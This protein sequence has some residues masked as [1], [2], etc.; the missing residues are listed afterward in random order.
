M[1]FKI[2]EW[3]DDDEE[4]EVKQN[5]QQPN[6]ETKSKM[7]LLVGTVICEF[8]GNDWT[9]YPLIDQDK[10]SDL[11]ISLKCP[12]LLQIP[13]K[14]EQTV[15][16]FLLTGGFDTIKKATSKL[17]LTINRNQSD[18]KE[19]VFYS[20][21]FGYNDMITPRFVHKTVNINDKYFL[22]IGGK[23]NSGW[24][25]ECELFVYESRKWI[26]FDKM[27]SKRSNFDAIL[28][29]QKI[30]VFG[31]FENVNKFSNHLVEVCD[32]SNTN[33]LSA[34]KWKALNVNFPSI[35][36]CRV[37]K[38]NEQNNIFLI[39]GCD[40]N[41][42]KKELYSF[43]TQKNE[44]KQVGILNTPRANFHTLY[45]NNDL[46]IIGGTFK[47]TSD[48]N[49]VSSN[50]IEKF[51]M[52]TFKSSLVTMDQNIFSSNISQCVDISDVSII[53]SEFGLPYSTSTQTNS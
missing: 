16:T 40:E 19:E 52:K 15:T 8:D 10:I 42:M 36:C 22:S 35:A 23:N 51:D 1:N 9:Y 7:V 18:N 48:I 43:D 45:E 30:Y 3:K 26:V 4:V 49:N 13:P 24:L 44:L 25:N 38:S 53:S 47:N 28:L 27:N 33:N 6:K 37:L 11:I 50:Y 5:N 2:S 20:L 41:V 17:C 14:T 31:G 39:G 12:S 32:F 29:N 21:N 46:Y 34:I